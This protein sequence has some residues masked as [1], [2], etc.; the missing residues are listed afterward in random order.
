MCILKYINIVFLGWGGEDDDFSN[1]LHS[2]GYSI[3]RY[4]PSIS[5][6]S[7]LKHRKEAPTNRR[8]I[9]SQDNDET[10]TT[11]QDDQSDGVRQ[12][13]YTLI[14]LTKKTLYTHVLVKL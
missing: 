9:V 7:M 14:E 10:P 1:R 13:E 4:D 2:S 12:L 5:R 3:V 6:Y 8:G 11:E